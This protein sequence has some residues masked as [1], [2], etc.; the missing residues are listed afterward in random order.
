MT[1]HFDEISYYRNLD[2]LIQY[3][4]TWLY[5]AALPNANIGIPKDVYVL[6]ERNYNIISWKSSVDGGIKGYYV[7]RS[8]TIGHADIET[9]AIILDTD[10]DG[11]THTCYVDYFTDN[12]IGTQYYY[13]IASINNAGFP[14]FHSD[15]AADINLENSYTSKK[16]L[17]T[18]Q[19]T[20]SYWT[21][22]DLYKQLGNIDTDRNIIPYRDLGNLYVQVLSDSGY[23]DMY[24]RGELSVKNGYLQD[25]K[26]VVP[27]YLRSISGETSLEPKNVPVKIDCDY[28]YVTTLPVSDIKTYTFYMDNIPLKTNKSS[29]TITADIYEDDEYDNLHSLK[30]DKVT[31]SSKVQES[32]T[33][34]FYWNDLNNYWQDTDGD[35]V[36]LNSLGISYEGTPKVDNVISIDLNQM[37]YIYFR[38][39]YI[40]NSKFL[41]TYIKSE[42]DIVYNEL[43]FKAYNHLIFASTLGKIFNQI[44]IDLKKAKGDL[45]TTDVS[46][47]LVYKN[48]ASYFNFEQPAWLGNTNYRRCVLGNSMTGEVGLW[49]AAMIGGSQLSLQQAVEAL[50]AGEFSI[51]SL[52][53]IDY[54]TCYVSSKDL[55]GSGLNLTEIFNYDPTVTYS[56]DDIVLINNNYFKVLDNTTIDIEDFSELNSTK[57]VCVNKDFK[58]T[59]FKKVYD[60]DSDSAN[61]DPLS[62]KVLINTEVITCNKY[63]IVSVD[64]HFYEVRNQFNYFYVILKFSNSE[65]NPFGIPN[66]TFYYNTQT[67]NLYKL[68]DGSWEESNGDLKLDALYF[69]DDNKKLYNFNGID[70]VDQTVLRDVN[71]ICESLTLNVPTIIY[72][73]YKLIGTEY[74]LSSIELTDSETNFIFCDEYLTDSETDPISYTHNYI[75]NTYQIEFDNW[76]RSIAAE[77]Y[78]VYGNKLKL[79]NP[80]IVYSSTNFAVY[81]DEAQTDEV[82][83]ATYSVNTKDGI[84]NWESTAFKPEDGSYVYITYV[85][86][87]RPDI[88]KLIELFKFPQINLN[89]MWVEK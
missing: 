13:A 77:K 46:D 1:N 67:K 53:D 85:V 66:G 71:K 86:D 82:P 15:W 68:V 70:L 72:A 18:D 74:Y 61:Y 64:S 34:S 44:Q 50:A 33:Y 29:I 59:L 25:L 16:Y 40:Y 38:I 23:P 9:I 60:N 20:Q 84:L 54:L 17:Y 51:T 8:K 65:P 83:S 52:A 78:L 43:T 12:E 2:P 36:D 89:Y 81:T 57:V 4:D 6:H 27:G 80:N 19:L 73:Y 5:G 62:I 47:S 88:K 39:P 41:Q 48:F 11:N 22:I 3:G 7:Y 32:G 42:D 24:L 31:F 69:N 75:I 26:K 14:S 79:N 45:Y 21:I 56:V 58:D 55:Q 28:L 30:V 49:Q 35:E 37:G 63:D 76:K 87:I 10:N